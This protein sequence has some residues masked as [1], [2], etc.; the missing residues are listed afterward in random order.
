MGGLAGFN[1]RQM[2]GCIDGQMDGQADLPMLLSLDHARPGPSGSPRDFAAVPGAGLGCPGAVSAI[3]PSLFPAPA[4][5][6]L[7][8][9]PNNC[10]LIQ[11]KKKLKI[12]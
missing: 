8:A 11:K 6:W 3:V 7:P 2:G 1:P 4:A 12:K 10:V 5:R 9:T